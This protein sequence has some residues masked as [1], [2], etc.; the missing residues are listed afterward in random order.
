MPPI[1]Q[2]IWNADL[3][4]LAKITILKN[5]LQAWFRIL[6]TRRGDKLLFVD[7]FAGPGKYSSGEEGSPITSM[8]AANA[9]LFSMG[10]SFSAGHIQCIFFEKDSDRFLELSNSVALVST[11]PK[12]KVD[13]YCC[14]FVQGIAQ[15]E[16]KDSHIFRSRAPTLVFA[17]PFGGTGIPFNT[18]AH[19]MG[20]TASELLINLDVDG[21]ARIFLA[22]T[23]NNREAQLTDL[24]GDDS[25]KGELNANE[26]MKKLTVQILALYKKRLLTI[27]G[28]DFVWSFAMRGKHN[29]I[30]YHLVFATKHPLGQKKMKEAMSVIDKTGNYT[31]SDAHADQHM[32]FGDNDD[33][34]YAQLLF[35][36]FNGQTVPIG[37]VTVFALNETPF[38]HSKQMLAQ[39]EAQERIQVKTLSNYDR[40]KGTFPEDKIES[41]TFGNFGPHLTQT[42][43]F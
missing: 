26:D 5:Y 31:F 3:H 14:E 15:L 28:V 11:H 19:C 7:G 37:Q 40:R 32:L 24:F 13:K 9:A 25:W 38:L 8:R 41:V 2:T 22:T 12:L 21:L 35:K 36:R 42:A 39:L 30:N 10:D 6:G 23:N 34:H 43:W 27:T 4:T 33:T 20:G 18:M 1:Q 16:A 17:D 29:A